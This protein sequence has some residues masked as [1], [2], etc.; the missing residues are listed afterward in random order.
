MIF[1]VCFWGGGC[2]GVFDTPSLSVLFVKIQI[3]NKIEW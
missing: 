3:L 2:V 1:L